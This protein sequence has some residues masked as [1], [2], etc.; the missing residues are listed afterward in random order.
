MGLA[1]ANIDSITT[2]KFIPILADNVYKST[3]LFILLNG[4][5]R[6]V[7][8]GGRSIVEPVLYDKQPSGSYAQFA[9]LDVTPKEIITDL[10]LQYKLYYAAATVSEHDLLKNYGSSRVM[11]FLAAQ[12]QNMEATLKDLLGGD[13]FKE[14]PGTNDIDSL[15]VAIDDNNTYAIIDRTVAANA[16]WKAN[17][18]D[19]AGAEPSFSEFQKMYGKCTQG[20]TAPDLVVVVQEVFNKLW[21]LSLPQQRYSEGDEVTVGWPFIRFNR[22]RIMVDSHIPITANTAPGYFLNTDFLKMV[23]HTLRDFSFTGWLTGINQDARTGRV[24]WA[25]NLVVNNPRFQG[26]LDNLSTA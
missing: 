11:D 13:L 12:M 3:P 21:T 7:L 20:D 26:I 22:A 19:L 5:G 16:F 1:W 17:V 23:V 4:K 14:A 15:F 25:G 18:T 9:T 10:E 2:R 8:D 6:I 24:H